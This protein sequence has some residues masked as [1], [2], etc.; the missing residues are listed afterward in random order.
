[1]SWLKLY[2]TVRGDD[3][4]EAVIEDVDGTYMGTGVYNAVGELSVCLRYRYVVK[5]KMSQE[6]VCNSCNLCFWYHKRDMVCE[7][8]R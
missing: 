8:G 3:E 4:E 6:G 7:K 5:F 1:M 2:E